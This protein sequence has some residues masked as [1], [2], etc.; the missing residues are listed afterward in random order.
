MSTASGLDVSG[1][2]AIGRSRVYIIVAFQLL[3]LRNA[4]FLHHY[5]W[6]IYPAAADR[7]ER[8]ESEH[9]PIVLPTGEGLHIQGGVQAITTLV[10]IFALL[11]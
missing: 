10:F 6:P 4:D 7:C 5:P 11:G 3:D 8:H 1:L 9:R 2:N